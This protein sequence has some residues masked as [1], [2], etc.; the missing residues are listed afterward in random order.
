[1]GEPWRLARNIWNQAVSLE[2]LFSWK[3]ALLHKPLS[4]SFNCEE[5]FLFQLIVADNLHANS[6]S[7]MWLTDA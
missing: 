6:S 1:M 3:Q 2:G 5:W 7:V 4:A